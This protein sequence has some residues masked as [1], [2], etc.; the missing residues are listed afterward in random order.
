MWPFAGRASANRRSPSGVACNWQAAR[1]RARAS[2]ARSPAQSAA[3]VACRNSQALTATRMRAVR[4]VPQRGHVT[5]PRQAAR[6]V[7]HAMAAD[8]GRRVAGDI[9][10]G[11][12]V[13]AA[14]LSNFVDVEQEI[15]MCNPGGMGRMAIGCLERFLCMTVECDV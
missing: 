7:G 4:S 10:E 8:A 2:V 6:Q 11:C 3:R 13:I 12:S 14:R 1:A 9:L 5:T 15:G